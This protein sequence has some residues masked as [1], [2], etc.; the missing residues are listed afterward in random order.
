MIFDDGTVLRL[1]DDRFVVTTTTGNAAAVLD[2]MEEWLQTEWPEL[3]VW[4]TSVTEQWATVAV[5]GPRSRDVRR[6][7]RPRPGRRRESFPFMTWRDGR[8]RRVARHASP[9]QLLAASLPTR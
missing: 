1:A 4:C 2:W 7:P 8:R 9:D 6:R 5:V 3:R